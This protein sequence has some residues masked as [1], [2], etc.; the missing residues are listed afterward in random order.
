M[1]VKKIIPLL[2][3]LLAAVGAGAQE[4]VSISGE[5]S[6]ELLGY[7]DSFETWEKIKNADL[8]DVLSGTLTVTA[9]GALAEAVASFDLAPVFDGS[10]SPL[11]LNE[12]YVKAFLGPVDLE[13]GYRKLTWGKADSFGPLD[14]TNPYDYRDLTSMTDLISLKIARPMLHASWSLG[15]AGMLEG[16]FE[17]WFQGHQFDL[18]GRWAPVQMTGMLSQ[19]G[20]LSLLSTMMGFQPTDIENAQKYI[21]NYI[22]NGEFQPDPS[23]QY[24]QGG[25]RFTTS[26]ASNDFGVQYFY[27]R[28]PRPAYKIDIAAIDF[29]NKTIDGTRLLN[30]SYNTFHQIGIDFARDLWGFNTR[31]EAAIHLT[32]DLK[33]DKGDVYNPFIGWSLG[34]DRTLFW[35]IT[36]NLQA[37]E[38]VRLFQNK[39]SDTLVYNMFPSDIESGKDITSTRITALLSRSFLRD[40]LEVKVTALWG[41]EDKDFLIMPALVWQKDGLSFEL[42]AGIFGGDD[43]GEL[44]QYDDNDYVRGTV[45]LVF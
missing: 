1:L 11:T 39:V 28:L 14:V 37:N 16:V 22:L 23:L 6:A 4:G 43:E 3:L 20:G 19:L 34:F 9:S 21:S 5:V 26:A 12:A 15:S 13:A 25:I 2:A 7:A 44:G 35:N 38:T 27:G 24:L 42:S 8:G 40:A 31:A 32:S 33:G 18:R 17:P 36:L 30:M 29:V 10:A 45:K 41:I